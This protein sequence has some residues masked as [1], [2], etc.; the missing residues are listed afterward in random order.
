MGILEGKVMQI[1][2]TGRCQCSCFHCPESCQAGICNFVM[3]LQ[4]LSSIIEKAAAED[5]SSII[6]TGGEPLL[7]KEVLFAGLE[8]A[9]SKNISVTLKSNMIAATDDDIY[10]M[11]CLGIMRI[12]SSIHAPDRIIHDGISGYEG[13]FDMTVHNLTAAWRRNIEVAVHMVVTPCNIKYFRDTALFARN[14]NFKFFATR[15]VCPINGDKRSM[16]G[17]DE[18]NSLLREMESLRKEGIEVAPFD[19]YPLCAAPRGCDT[20]L[21]KCCPAG[22]EIFT[23]AVDGSVRACPHGGHNFVI[24]NL[25]KEDVSAIWQKMSPWRDDSLLPQRCKDCSLLADCG[26]GCR[27]EAFNDNGDITGM[28]P[29]AV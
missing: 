2:L 7:C 9:E 16:L 18:F 24:G 11:Y 29:Y 27:M 4:D 6:F 5:V 13:S 14:I 26:G 22:K 12:V 8:M 20:S 19:S 3:D 1:G 17:K 23:V 28:D 10:R 25:L 15:A 21:Y